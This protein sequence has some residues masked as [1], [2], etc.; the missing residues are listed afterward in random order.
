MQEVLVKDNVLQ[1]KVFIDDYPN[2][3]LM[4]SLDLD[5]LITDLELEIASKVEKKKCRKLKKIINNK[6]GIPP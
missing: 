3:S 6:G 5:L 2:I 1:L 4:P